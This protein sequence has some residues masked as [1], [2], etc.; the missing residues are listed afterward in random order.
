MEVGVPVDDRAAI[1]FVGPVPERT[2]GNES[3][4]F[5]VIYDMSYS[6]GWELR[7]DRHISRTGFQYAQLRD[8]RSFRTPH[9]DTDETAS[10][11]NGQTSLRCRILVE[12]PSFCSISAAS[13]TAP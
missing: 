2:F 4:Y 10:A 6:A 11:G 1:P 5:G 9:E 12:T 3:G 8:N 7:I 13:F